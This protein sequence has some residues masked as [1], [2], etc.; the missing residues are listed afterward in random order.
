MNPLVIFDIETTGLSKTDDYIIQFSAIKVN[1]ETNKL[2]DT[3]NLF[4]RPDKDY[5]M[6]IAAYILHRIHPDF[7]KDKPTFK[8]VANDIYNF[9][10]GCD[11]LTYNGTGFDIPILYYHFRRAGINWSPKDHVCYDAFREELRRDSH[12]LDAM[13]KK[14]CGRTMEEAGLQAHDGLADAKATFAVYRH[15]KEQGG[16]NPETMLVEDDTIAN[17]DYE[18][19]LVPALTYGRYKNVPIEIV[20]MTDKAYLTWVMGTEI[21][22]EAKNIIKNIIDNYGKN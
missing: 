15:Q 5:V 17:I 2:I 9:I 13:F 10:N 14:Y 8:E 20:C 12:K 21:C 4:I 18:G 7:L 3:M 6:S 22:D 1:Q 16:V 11:I 19:N